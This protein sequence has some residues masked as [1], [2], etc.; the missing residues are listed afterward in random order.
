MSAY[1]PTLPRET[2]WRIYVALLRAGT[3]GSDLARAMNSRLCDLEET[4]EIG[5]LI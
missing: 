4:I 2:Q 3:T 1:V 5:G